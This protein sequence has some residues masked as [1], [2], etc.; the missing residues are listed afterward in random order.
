[1]TAKRED[2][3]G[4]EINKL[5]LEGASVAELAQKFNAGYN[6]IFRRLKVRRGAT[7]RKDGYGWQHR[8]DMEVK[9]LDTLSSKDKNLILNFL[10]DCKAERLSK[11][12][13]IHYSQELR[14][15]NNYRN[16]DL[17]S[18]SK[19]DI[20]KMINKI[21]DSDLSEW[22]KQGYRICFKKFYRWFAVEKKG[23]KLQPKE[24]PENV[25]WINTTMKEAKQKLPED[26]LN[27]DDVKKLIESADTPRD[28]ALI[29]LLW[30]SGC[31]IGELLNL[32]LKNLNFDRYGATILVSGKTGSR[33][34]RLVP[35]VPYL[36]TLKENHP[37]KNNN[38]AFLFVGDGSRNH[39]GRLGYN[40][41]DSL[42]RKLKA[43]AKISKRVHVHGFRHAR[44]SNL[45]KKV[46]EPVMR[47]LF[48][49]TQKSQ[50]TAV[51]VHLSERDIRNEK[52]RADGVEVPEDEAEESKLKPVKCVRCSTMNA[53]TAAYCMKCSMILDEA[54]AKETEKQEAIAQKGLARIEKA[55]IK[56]SLRD[57]TKEVIRDMIKH[58][59]LKI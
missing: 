12:R 15:S 58:G 51:Y 7:K 5:Y 40:A 33:K 25:S 21:E 32:Q 36:A 57:V 44:A 3:N 53:P 16:K 35:S 27:E 42:L 20:K 54:L 24:Y 17:E 2:L 13:L 48:G 19:E 23:E 38:V 39:G 47:E 34:I 56:G 59:E 26:I 9:R 6:T 4:A 8:Y 46:K 41:I 29:A 30:D 50:M 14:L 22:S 31:R 28:K 52:L 10:E 49:W 1:M 55:S 45:A 11:P 18:M 43:K 37:D